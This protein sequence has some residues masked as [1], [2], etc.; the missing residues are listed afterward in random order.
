VSARVFSL[1]IMK[2]QQRTR[3]TGYLV[4]SAGITEWQLAIDSD[5]RVS[6][7]RGQSRHRHHCH[8]RPSAHLN[9]D[10]PRRGHV[11]LASDGKTDKPDGPGC[12]GVGQGHKL[13]HLL[14]QEPGIRPSAPRANV[15]PSTITPPWC[16]VCLDNRDT[17]VLSGPLAAAG[18]TSSPRRPM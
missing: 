3:D 8:I 10:M 13:R 14:I 1:T 7:H 9:G 6:W 16:L 15:Y 5:A 4:V 12:V 11:G 18:L 17:T 2:F